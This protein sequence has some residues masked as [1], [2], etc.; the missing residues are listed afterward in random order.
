MNSDK[1]KIEINGVEFEASPGQMIIEVTDAADIYVPRFCYHRKLSVAANCRMCL[2]EVEKAPKPLPACATPVADGMRVFTKSALAISAQKS[3]M[4]FL[5]I[6]HPLDCPICDQGGECEL[7]DIAMGYGRGISRFNER[8]RVVKDKNLGPL[9]STDMTRCIHCTRCVRFGQEIAGIQELGTIGRGEHTEISTYI[10]S[11]VDHELSGNIIDVCPVG[12]LNNKPYRFSARAWEMAQFPTVSPHDCVGSNINAHV[13]QGKLKRVVPRVNESI[14]E[15]WIADRDRFSCEAV[16]ADDR[17]E[18]PMVRIDGEWRE[19]GW[20]EALEVAARGLQSVDGNLAA[21]VSPS[22]TTEEG[23]LTA[24][25]VRH[26]GSGNLDHR[27]RRCDFRQQNLDPVFPWLGMSVEDV[28]QMKSLLV[29]G[30]NLRREVPMLAHRVRKAAVAGAHVS[31]VNNQVYDYLFP[32]A[33]YLQNKDLVGELSRLVLAAAGNDADLSPA[34]I[35]LVESSKAPSSAHQAIAATLKDGGGILLGQI[36]MRHPRFAE[37]RLLCAE[38]GRLTG[39]KLGYLPEGANTAGLSL[40]GV[41]PHRGI[42]GES[43]ATPG[44]A[45][46]D[47]ISKPPRG[48]L[49]VGIEPDLDCANG[50]KAMMAMEKAEFVLVLSPFLSANFLKYAEV[51]LPMGTFAETSGTF[52]N[53]AG[54]WQSFSGVAQPVAESRPGWKILRVLGNLID[55]PDCAYVSSD[56]VRDE[57]RAAVVDVKPDNRISLDEAPKAGASKIPP[58]DQLDVPMYRIDSLVRRAHSLQCTRDGQAGL[59]SPDADRQI[60]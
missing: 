58:G 28:G 51:I 42:G 34:I 40:A 25:L 59:S 56:A 19:C 53:A 22:A 57:L 17:L 46:A 10:E 41:L 3:V 20:D 7:Q 54:E 16:Y 45:A 55:L 37:L 33:N 43:L 52:I 11:S 31:F 60:A 5:L 23:Y 12:A 2:V 48:L 39:A 50:P 6:N 18:T 32:V 15:T 29:V 36:G 38:L 1:F 8:K 13:L 47:I 21:L 14:N 9:I 27:L 44:A 4:E 30:S 24:R 49:L 35:R 26:L